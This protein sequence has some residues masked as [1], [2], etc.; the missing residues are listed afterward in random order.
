[1]DI[2]N[3]AVKI[4]EVRNLDE[5]KSV[6]K[7]LFELEESSDKNVLLASYIAKRNAIINEKKNEDSLF[8]DIFWLISA[9]DKS[10]NRIGKLLYR[11]KE[12]DLL[13][14]AELNILFEMYNKKRDKIEK[15]EEE[16]VEIE[17]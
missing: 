17:D 7:E 4:L 9:P 16:R 8:A 2:K 5:L 11:L 6:G 3:L 14:K 1:M 12:T 13:S 15:K 10:Y